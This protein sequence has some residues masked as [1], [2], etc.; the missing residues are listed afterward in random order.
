MK[1]RVPLSTD[2]I[3]RMVEVFTAKQR[4]V[5]GPMQLDDFNLYG[6][7]ACIITDTIMVLDGDLK[8]ADFTP[9]ED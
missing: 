5:V 9:K 3:T 6:L 7:V 8:I 2:D 1:Q 4:L